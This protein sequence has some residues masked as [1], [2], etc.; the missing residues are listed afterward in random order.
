VAAYVLR[1]LAL[2]PPLLIGVSL[3]LFVLTHL[4]PADPA[5]LI[6]KVTGY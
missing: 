3:L 1:R 6:A 4:I 2:I 5:K